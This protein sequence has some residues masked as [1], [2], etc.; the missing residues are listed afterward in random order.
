MLFTLT[1]PPAASLR[2]LVETQRS[3]GFSYPEVGATRGEP[4]R[5]ADRDHNRTLLGHGDAVF[6]AAREAIRGWR[7]FDLGW[8]EIVP[9]DLIRE[10]ECAVMVTRT[11]GLWSANVTRVVYVVD[12]EDAFGFAYGTLPHHAESGEERFLVER[13]PDGSVTYDIL[14]FSR[15]E[16]PIV[17]LCKPLA[18]ALQRRFARDSMAAMRSAVAHSGGPIGGL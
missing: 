7:M 4:P 1:R 13:G 16:S 14:A 5:H 10:G 6:A 15:P 3:L 8:L 11:L 9:P 18:R 12:E 17:R 2:R